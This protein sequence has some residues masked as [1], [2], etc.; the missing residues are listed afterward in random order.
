[1]LP[2]PAQLKAEI[3]GGPLAEELTSFWADVFGPH[4]TKQEA[5]AYREGKLKPDA[6]WEIHRILTDTS[7][8]TK[9]I[10][11]ITR[12]AF[13]AAAAP[14]ALALPNL[15]VTKQ[16]QWTLLLNLLTGGNDD[17]DI[18]RPQVQQMLSLA[19]QDGLLTQE[20]RA[21]LVDGGTTTQSR[22]DEL[23]WQI[24]PDLIAQA[25]GAE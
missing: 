1:M 4:P 22:T 6:A 17:V 12:G 10:K 20:Q 21:V 15:S 23:D 24:S 18:T 19:L 14:M 25:K 9:T 2:T 16:Q 7:R 11:T 5:M 13:L 8:R 3:E